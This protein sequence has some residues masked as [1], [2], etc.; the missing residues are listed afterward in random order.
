MPAAAEGF[1]AEVIAAFGRHLIVRD[2]ALREMRARPSGRRLSIVCGDRVRCEHDR[3]HDE[4]MVV[5]VR[6]RATL[7]ARSSL[8]GD[9]EPVVANVT[10]LIVVIAPK[11]KP[12]YFIID[13]YLCAATAAGIAGAVAVNKADL[14]G[15]AVDAEELAV[16]AAVGYPHITCSAK[17][18]SGLDAL[19]GLLSR[20]VSVLVG[21]SG[22]GKS[23][24]VRALLPRAA[25]ETGELVREEEGRHTTTASRA[26][27]L[28]SGGTLMDSP[29]VRDFA[30]ALDHLDAKTLG[31]PEIA[32]RAPACRFADC[33]HMQEP[34]CAVMT[35]VEAREISARRYE[36]YRRLRRRHAELTQ[37]RGYQ[38]KR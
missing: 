6:P 23:S 14:A 27:A 25:V 31:F 8:R 35:A 1:D 34:A 20:G 29:G 13:R 4:M 9:S 2:A 22:V 18:G 10:Q 37:A 38:K 24:L 17:S 28:D 7:L 26:Y 5:E 30:P 32:Q 3:V 15:D 33:K 16:L 12:D 19:R 36:S 11:P 21:Q